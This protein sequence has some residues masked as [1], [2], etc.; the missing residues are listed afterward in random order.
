MLMCRHKCCNWSIQYHQC[1][2]LHYTTMTVAVFI[3][4]D[5]L[6]KHMLS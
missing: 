2:V 3:F 6:S 1:F 4:Y 5:E